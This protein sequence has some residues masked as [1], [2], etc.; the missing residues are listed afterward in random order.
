LSPEAAGFCFHEV[1]EDP[2]STGFQRPGAVPFTLTRRAFTSHLEGIAGSPWSPR[3]VTE[4][5]A[6]A[7]TR[8]LLLTFDD[9]GRSALHAAD[10]LG[11]RGWRGHFFITT[12][13][14]ASATFLAAG[15]TRYLH[16]CGHV[17]GS[18]SHT[19]PD[20]FRELTPIQGGAGRWQTDPRRRPLR[21][22][23]VVSGSGGT[24]APAGP[25][26]ADPPA[27]RVRP[28]HGGVWAVRARPRARTVRVGAAARS[29]PERIGQQP[30]AVHRA[31]APASRFGGAL[32]CAGSE[33]TDR[34]CWS[35]VTTADLPLPH[36]AEGVTVRW[37][38][39]DAERLLTVLKGRPAGYPEPYPTAA[40][41]GGVLPAAAPGTRLEVS[42]RDD[43]WPAFGEW[44]QGLG[45]LVD[46]GQ[47]A[48]WGIARSLRSAPVLEFEVDRR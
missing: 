33:G 5:G 26:L 11:R 35:F 4:L 6:E 17:V 36:G 41:R 39:G 15:E 43:R 47:S 29:P 30:Q 13:R 46:L 32:C 14:I 48:G 44:T 9:G 21:R 10:E 3:L 12:G 19:H 18:H 7:A 42:N 27:V 1:P 23:P 16:G 2:R 45:E 24:G 20:I 28:G 22:P 25:A 31:G 37:L 38:W 8:C 40:G 34:S